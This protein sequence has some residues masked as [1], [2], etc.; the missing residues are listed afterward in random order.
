MPTYETLPPGARRDLVAALHGLYR[1]AGKPSL[2]EISVGIKQR[3]ELPTTVSYDTASQL[4]HGVTVPAWAR[5]ES[6]VRYLAATA[7]GRQKPE[8]EGEVERFHQLWLAVEDAERDGS[9]GLLTAE[10]ALRKELR[11]TDSERRLAALYRLERL[12]WRTPPQ[13]RET[14]AETWRSVLVDFIRECRPLG[15]HSGPE[16]TP[17]EDLQ[18]AVLILGRLPGPNLASRFDLSGLDL[19]NLIWDG[20]NLRYVNLSGSLLSGSSLRFAQLAQARLVKATLT[21]A[22]LT[23]A[24]LTMADL[25]GCNLS[26]AFMTGAELTK[27]DLSETELSGADLRHVSARY[28]VLA[29]CRAERARGCL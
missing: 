4:L 29:E 12:A 17:P 8:P 11:S 15:V 16:P 6:M 13:E 27:A 9:T 28:A 5:V 19:R 18:L 23:S 26:G 2:R 22:D 10:A 1:G 14:I 21:N 7:V 20:A 24:E 25:T 3:N